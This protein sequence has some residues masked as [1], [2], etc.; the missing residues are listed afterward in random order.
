MNITFAIDD[1]VIHRARRRASALGTTVD[2]LVR[3]YLAQLPGTTDPN[4]DA[5]E[6]QKRSRLAQGDFRGWKFNREQLHE[7][8]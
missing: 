4:E 2:Q 8:R 5:A 7:R 6:F 3:D 1:D